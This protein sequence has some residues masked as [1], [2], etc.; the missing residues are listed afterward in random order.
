MS[1]SYNIP[2]QKSLSVE[3]FQSL[4]RVMAN[5]GIYLAIS[6]FYIYMVSDFHRPPDLIRLINLH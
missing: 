3:L 2:R 6:G 4:V 1:L 5:E